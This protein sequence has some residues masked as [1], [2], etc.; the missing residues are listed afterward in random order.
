MQPE[1]Q[2]LDR[3]EFLH[4]I[5]RC[6]EA[7]REIKAKLPE[8]AGYH[9]HRDNHAAA[10]T[11]YLSKLPILCD[12]NSFQIYVA[13]I[14]HAASLGVVDTVD[15]G[16]FCHIA[17]TAMS[18]WKLANLTVPAAQKKEKQAQEKQNATRSRE[19]TPLPS[20]G[21]HPEANCSQSFSKELQQA[22]NNLPTFEVQKQHFQSLRNG[23]MVLPS[24]S[25]LRD[26]PLAALHF[27]Q[28]AEQMLREEALA[29]N[30]PPPQAVSHQAPDPQPQSR[31]AA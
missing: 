19:G 17:Q 28:I 16:R 20:K 8:N 5:N 3:D 26:N 11:A 2:P 13:C 4:A 21:N 25:E 10:S 31:Q 29:G 22:L 7:Y 1:S 12:L 30:P 6:I 9:D 18:A 15:I 23:G 27:C 14:G 24:D